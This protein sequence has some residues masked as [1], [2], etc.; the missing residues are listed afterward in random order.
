MVRKYIRII[1]KHNELKIYLKATYEY[2][3]VWKEFKSR[4]D[5]LEYL[6]NYLTK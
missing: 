3:D 6:I 1:I 4:K 5:L 2:Q